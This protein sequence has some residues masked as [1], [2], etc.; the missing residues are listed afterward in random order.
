MHSFQP[1]VSVELTEERVPD[2]APAECLSCVPVI[3]SRLAEDAQLLEG[4]LSQIQK[5]M[6][7]K[8]VNGWIRQ[9]MNE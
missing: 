8:I 7:S 5:R 2:L 1:G 3:A 4:S 6:Q 9:G